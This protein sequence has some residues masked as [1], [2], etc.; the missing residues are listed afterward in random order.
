MTSYSVLQRTQEIAI[1]MALGARA[2]DVTQRIVAEGGAVAL[3]GIALGMGVALALT[4]SIQKML[5]ETQPM[6]FAT[7]A[8]VAA[9]LL[10]AALA[11]CYLPDRTATRVDP[12]TILRHE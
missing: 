9:L 7:Y 10:V 8:G 3:V 2:E 6:D 1:R 4:R 5:F 12:I 11:A